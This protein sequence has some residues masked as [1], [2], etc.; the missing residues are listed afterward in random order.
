M[1][2]KSQM[3][4]KA[5]FKRWIVAI[6]A[7][8]FLSIAHS[9]VFATNSLN[10]AAL[11]PRDASAS[12]DLRSCL[13]QE[14]AILDVYY[15]IDNSRSMVSI[16][17]KVGTDPTGLRFD[18][19]ESSLVPLVELAGNAERGTRVNVA[20]G[21]FS[22]D[23]N[24][25]VEWTE[26]DPDNRSA[27]A[28]ISETL[29]VEAGGGTNWVAGLREAQKQLLAQKSEPG[30]HCQT[31]VWV[32]DGGIDIEQNL[33]L[34]TEGVVEL[35]G[36]SPLEIGQP[37][38]DT[39]L[40][41]DIRNSGIIVL[42][43]LIQQAPGSGEE[44]G[45]NPQ[46]IRDSK[47]SY[48]EPVVLGSGLVDAYYFNGEVPL[49]G[50]FNCGN[51]VPGSQGQVLQIQK[52][53][54]LRDTF[55][56][57]VTCIAETCTQLPPTAVT[58]DGEK[59]EISIPKGIASMQLTVP[60][61]FR[62]DQVTAPNGSG[63]C[64]PGVCSTVEEIRETGTF[65][66]LVNNQ[67]G[68]WTIASDVPSL[69]P[70]LFSGLEIST[71]PI[72]IDPI[73]REI[74]VD[75]R[76]GQ[77]SNVE[78]N[79]D[80]YESLIFDAF[81]RFRNEVSEKA[82]ITPTRDGWLLTW[83]PTETTPEGVSPNEV[84]ISLAATA[85]GDATS[86]PVVPSLKL[87][88][89]EQPFPVAL[90]NLGQYPSIIEPARG[91][92]LIFSP[93]EGKAGVGIGQIVVQGPKTN[94]GAICWDS[95]DNGFIGEYKDSQSQVD[96]QLFASRGSTQDDQ[97]LCPSGQIG[98]TVQQNTELNIPIELT[99]SD[100]AE[101]LITGTIDISLYGPQGEPGFSRSLDFTAET[102]VV[103]SGLA[104]WIVLAI[105]TLLGVGIPYA[106][107]VILARR[108][109]AFSS[110]L[111]GTR[112]AALPATVGPEGLLTLGEIDPSRYEFI[113]VDKKKLTRTI[114][115]GNECHKVIPPT[116]WPFK[117]AKTVVIGPDGSS[118]FTN[119]DATFEA[120]RSVGDSSQALGN[121]FY[122]VAN[123]ISSSGEA[124]E[125]ASDDWGNTVQLGD[126]KTGA[127]IPISGKVVLLAQGNMDAP[128]AISKAN[129]DVRTW[130]GWPNVYTAMTT[131]ENISQFDGSDSSHK[132]KSP[133][134][135]ESDVEPSPPY[136]VVSDDWGFGSPTTDS[137]SASPQRKSRFG[138]K[139]TRPDGGSATS[140]PP[141]DFDSNDW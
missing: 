84:I 72:E 134:V 85:A 93:I 141:F 42:G 102:T 78:F 103:K 63:A 139:A 52:A 67:P 15:L 82:N 121:I 81:V 48:F 61:D 68:I 28:G 126:G 87:E 45:E 50:D 47:V 127:D 83:Q 27:I 92:I 73:T 140:Q 130:Y 49:T 138:R 55:Q 77:G 65:R 86:T 23:G 123:P 2:K 25:L 99:S 13:S 33:E 58:C 21:L 105:L 40:M 62:P 106:A 115:T 74:S 39:G 37:A 18:A 114:E 16:G 69:N 90:K 113:F 129:A 109:A 131:G 98:V 19:V 79:K 46:K 10:V 44:L 80:N 54:Q 101:G 112:W 22:K 6:L 124:S 5:K 11:S 88:R 24:T 66:V 7:L 136:S 76:L 43:V 132:S 122:F 51:T 20:G 70:L 97:I 12:I 120:G 56:E 53:E 8:S 118:I 35:C 108:Q 17:G 119:H 100:Q 59:C 14:N 64:L 96:R 36:I 41:F 31:L 34:T 60:T 75:V 4:T 107:L 1:S 29:N 38:E 26:I 32:T 71:N 94:P 9:T 133:K 137:G 3:Q 104:F 57:L 91:E 89:I 128:E 95:D 30:I 111:D 117:P 125:F 116:F 110:Q 135:S